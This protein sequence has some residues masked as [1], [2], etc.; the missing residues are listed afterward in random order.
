MRTAKW[1]RPW[2]LALAEHAWPDDYRTI[3]QPLALGRIRYVQAVNR[4]RARYDG[5]LAM[6]AFYET[7]GRAPCEATPVVEVTCQ[8]G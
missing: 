6:H 1:R 3:T 2:F 4:M 5:A 7:A 8:P